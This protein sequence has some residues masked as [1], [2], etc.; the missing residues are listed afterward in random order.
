MVE[1]LSPPG[2]NLAALS[3]ALLTLAM[4]PGAPV[5]D[6]VFAVVLV[7][8]SV[9]W[10]ASLPRPALSV[11]TTAPAPVREGEVLELDV[12]LCNLGRSPLLE[13]GA[14]AARLPD[15]LRPLQDGVLAGDLPVGGSLRVRLRFTALRRGRW[16]LE[17]PLGFQL[18]PL[19]LARALRRPRDALE[20]VIAPA[21]LAPALLS[22][23]DRGLP[24]AL[25]HAESG[26]PLGTRPWREGDRL[27]DLHHRAWARTG[28]PQVREREAPRPAGVWLV[29]ET[30]ALTWAERRQV[31]A[32]LRLATAWA[33]DLDSRGRLGGVRL[34]GR[35]LAL[36]EGPGR[37]QARLEAFAS[38]PSPGW[39]RWEPPRTA[40]VQDLPSAPVRLVGV[41]GSWLRQQAAELAPRPA[42]QI[43]QVCKSPSGRPGPVLE[44]DG[45][46]RAG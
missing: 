33:D 2:K 15:A 8:L 43:V 36:P 34:D 5:A 21:P 32:L 40:S 10:L 30:G 18:E 29:V 28:M 38:V 19:G 1:R 14:L 45:R 12:E 25:D 37:V 9:A 6:V 39:G 7:A 31:E 16:R 4:L 42:L 22:D 27:R 35:P 13:V 17:A 41:C 23:P 3:L 26:E 20:V 11:H 44:V 24:G 46:G